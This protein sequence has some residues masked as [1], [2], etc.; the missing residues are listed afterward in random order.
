M[1]K[2][3]VIIGNG[4][5]LAHGYRTSAKDFDA[6][7]DATPYKEFEENHLS[8]NWNDTKTPKWWFEYEKRIGEDLIDIRIAD[9]RLKYDTEK[10]TWYDF[11]AYANQVYDALAHQISS[12][13]KLAYSRNI[14]ASKT[15]LSSI[16]ELLRHP[17]KVIVVSFNYTD[18]AKRYIHHV[19]HI[20]GSLAENNIVLGFDHTDSITPYWR[21]D[22]SDVDE[23]LIV[24]R[25]KR[26]QRIMT[27][28]QRYCKKA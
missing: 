26:Y 23:W 3:L 2:T 15:I 27:E 22:V 19:Y 16:K 12:Y 24:K 10:L 4:F 18:T 14:K 11:L 8:K 1:G 9:D 17:K 20:H 13:L 5:D 28:F 7:L 25:N 21:S 6:S